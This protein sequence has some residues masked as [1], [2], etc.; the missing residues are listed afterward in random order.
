[1]VTVGLKAGNLFQD[2]HVLIAD[3]E[4]GLRVISHILF[5]FAIS[6]VADRLKPF[7][8]CV[9]SRDLECQM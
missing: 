3:Y 2:F 8:G 6:L 4:V 7:I 9:L 1:M 5:Q